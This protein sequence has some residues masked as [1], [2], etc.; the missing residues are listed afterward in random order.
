VVVPV[1][2]KDLQIQQ[3]EVHQQVHL[4]KGVETEVMEEALLIITKAVVEAVLEV[5]LVMVEMVVE[6]ALDQMELAA[7][8]EEL[9]LLTLEQ[10]M[11]VGVLVFQL[12]VQVVLEVHRML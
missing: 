12:K 8:A 3:Q 4:E 11:E 7:V 10:V 2:K 1:D 6:L 5:T 9:D